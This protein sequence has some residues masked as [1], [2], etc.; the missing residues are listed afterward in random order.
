MKILLSTHIFLYI[1]RDR[2]FLLIITMKVFYLFR[3]EK[4]RRMVHLGIV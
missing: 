3:T 1:T 4:P 2:E